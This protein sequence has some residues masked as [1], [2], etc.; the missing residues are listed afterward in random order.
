[1]KISFLGGASEV[2]ASCILLNLANKNILLDCGIRQGSAKDPL[3]DFRTIQEQ[4]GIDAIV[5]SHAHMDHTGALPL[6]SKEY[7]NAR[8]YM[9]NMTKDLIRVLLYDSLKI[10]NNREAEIPLYSEIDVENMLN[11]IFTIN[12][13]NEFQIFEDIKLTF[14]LAGHVAGASCV[15]LTSP[16]GSLFYSGD[17][18]TFS[19]NSIEG[20]KIPKIRPDAAIFEATYGDKLHSNRELEEDR[21]IEIVEKCIQGNG[22]MLIPAFALGRAQE[23]ILILKRAINRGRLKAFNIYVDGMVKDI[24]RAYKRNPLFLKSTIG[25]KILKG[26]D[27]FYDNNVKAIE[28]KEQR[29][30]I[31]NSKEAAV[32]IASSGML[33][34]GPSLFFAENLVSKEDSYIVFTGYQDEEAPGQKLLNLLEAKEDERI[35]EI[36]NKTIPVKC[37]VERVGLSAHSDK[38]EIKSLISLLNPKN[39]IL[40]HGDKDIISSF[41]KELAEETW[42]R[43]YAPKAGETVHLEVINPRKQLKKSFPKTLEEKAPLSDTNIEKLWTLITENYADR[44]FTIEELLTL[45]HG[46]ADYNSEEVYEL[47][48]LLFNSAYFENDFRRLFMFKA[49]SKADIEEALKPKELK[50]NE[51]GELAAQYFSEFN[52]KKAGIKQEEKKIVL[53]F[54]FP[55]ALND[56][57]HSKIKAFEAHTN[58]T[59]E[60]NEA[61]NHNAAEGILKT[62][63]KDFPIKKISYFLNE[64]KYVVN[65]E[66][67]ILVPKDKLQEF[68]NITGFDLVIKSPSEVLSEVKTPLFSV[69]TQN[70]MEQNQALQYIDMCFS[71]EEFKPYKKSIKPNTLIELTFISPMVGHRYENKIKEIAKDIGWNLSISPSSNQS[72][73]I[74][75]ASSL[76]LENGITLKKNPS[77]NPSNYK[78]TLKI[79]EPFDESLLQDIKKDFEYKTGCSLDF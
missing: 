56:D 48:K 62:I 20:A 26:T 76:C 45:W 34:G 38:G 2:G 63:L 23:V 13:Q 37:T 42:H 59:V 19:Q 7:P 44:T 60:L 52:Y 79:T 18:S 73:I 72:E 33:T 64:G 17:F 24:N 10:M 32:I 9:N 71:S 8:I 61:T 49:K 14:Y 11:R 30:E 16:G 15:Y 1:M 4:G 70:S 40:V 36:N 22:K 46:N 53:S 35:L 27:P 66:K 28:N 67:D 39:I 47:Q 5:I 6:I 3:P 31:L 55:K 25:K 75:L 50:Q 74:A 68:K 43:I 54:D 57:I 69:D 41:A 58:W 77:F 65:L 78:V 21:L 51:I 29:E 12:Y